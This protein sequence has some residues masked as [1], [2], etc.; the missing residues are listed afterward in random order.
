MYGTIARLRVKEG[1]EADLQ[2]LNEEFKTLNVPG[3]IGEYVYRMDA[4]PREC[5]LVVLFADRE[6]YRKNAESADQNQRYEQFRALLESDPEWHDGEI[7]SAMTPA[8]VGA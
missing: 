3:Y 1:A 8:T 6:S 2:R 5:Y 7:I 4:D